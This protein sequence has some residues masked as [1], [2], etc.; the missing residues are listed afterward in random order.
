[1]MT[2]RLYIDGNDAYDKYGV[3]VT[4]NGWNELIA[5]PPLKTVTTNDW[6]EEDGVE[7]DLE[8]P[9]L[10]THEVQ[11]SFA[12]SG[13]MSALFTMIDLLCDG[14][15]HEF[16]SP[17]IGRSF[18]L[19]LVSQPNYKYI[20]TLETVTLKFADDFPLSGDTAITPKSSLFVSEDYDLDDVL[21]STYGVRVLD[22]SLAEIKKAPQIKTNLLR[23][24]PS[25]A[26]VIYDGS[27][28]YQRDSDGEIVKD[29]NGQ[30][31]V[32][33]KNVRYKSKD[34]K[35]TCL[36][37]ANSLTELWRNWDALLYALIQPG[38]RM[39]YVRD[40][41]TTF[42]CYYKQCQV[43]NFFP[44]GKI[45]LE[46]T[47]TLVFHRDFRITDD[48]ILC[49]EDGTPVCTEDYEDFIDLTPDK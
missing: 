13:S 12:V 3:Y 20:R 47:L 24:I 7:P 38:E 39:L 48:I 23:N 36:M 2:G 41:E 31:I 33:D 37:R 17:S 44:E 1:M 34:V 8:A 30:P 10:N 40:I 9:V 45:W 28:V 22:G 43:T 6:Q 11:L 29:S 25:V 26:G 42:P 14:A 21:L 18:T 19:R 5:F 32:T 46:F 15:Y 49:T 4:E 16:N 35:L 27:R